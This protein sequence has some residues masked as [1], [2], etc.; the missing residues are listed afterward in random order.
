M[1]I[2]EINE[3][4]D[5]QCEEAIYLIT[6]SVKRKIQEIKKSIIDNL[7]KQNLKESE[8]QKKIETIQKIS[9]RAIIY[10]PE[11]SWNLFDILNQR[12]Y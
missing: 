3:K 10:H 2:D 6:M 8:L 7:R 5:E 12:E 4:C 1:D 11:G 9:R